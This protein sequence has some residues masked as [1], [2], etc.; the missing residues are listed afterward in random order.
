METSCTPC[1]P[2]FTDR[3]VRRVRQSLFVCSQQRLRMEVNDKRSSY[4]CP[5]TSY[6]SLTDINMY[7]W[8]CRISVA[9]CTNSG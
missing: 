1:V 7:R 2:Y 8:Y 6:L 5:N 3:S 4:I 9:T